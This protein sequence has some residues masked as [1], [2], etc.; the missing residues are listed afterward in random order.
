MAWIG[1][2]ISAFLTFGSFLYNVR[3]ANRFNPYSGELCELYLLEHMLPDGHPF[4]FMYRGL[5][6]TRLFPR[7]FWPCVA[8]FACAGTTLASAVLAGVLGA[9][10]VLESETADTIFVS[11]SIC[12][13]ITVDLG[14]M[15]IPEIQNKICFKRMF[16][17]T[18]GLG[19]N[20]R[21]E[22]EKKWPGFYGTGK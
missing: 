11:L 5:P 22:I 12:S 18:S 10:G 1:V 20:V 13:T 16:K 3:Y 21:E 17:T 2:A 14:L 7:L 9:N 6:R 8:T 15:A 4:E 19:F